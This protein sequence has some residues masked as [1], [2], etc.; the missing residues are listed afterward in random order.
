N[1]N[2]K[3]IIGIKQLR[4]SNSSAIVEYKG[5][6][7]PICDF[8]DADKI[9]VEGLKVQLLQKAGDEQKLNCVINESSQ[10]VEVVSSKDAINEFWPQLTGKLRV[11]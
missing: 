8:A 7:T 6:E 11:E 9:N 4:A 10:K 1:I 5:F 2:N 3:E